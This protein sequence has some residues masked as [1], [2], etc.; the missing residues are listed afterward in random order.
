MAQSATTGK[1]STNVA[2]AKT[3]NIY[4]IRQTKNEDY[5]SLVLV[6]GSDDAR[7]FISVPINKRKTVFK[8]IRD[9]QGNISA[10]AVA[11][12]YLAPLENKDADKAADKNVELP[13]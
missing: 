9:T 1:K 5:F 11:V 13:F 10:I 8:P 12:K 4:G 3:Y 2:S 6:S 7:D